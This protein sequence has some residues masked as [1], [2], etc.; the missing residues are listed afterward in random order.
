MN[1][2]VFFTTMPSPIGLLTLTSDGRA[3]TSV[4]FEDDEA[5]QRPP[6]GWLRDER[7]L[8][9]ARRQLEEYFAG[10]RAA[11]DLP[12]A[13]HGTP[14]QLRVWRA[15]CAIPFGTTASYGEIARRIGAPAASRAVGG[16]NHRNPIAIVVPCHRVIG[17]DGSLTGYGGGESRKRKLL[18]LER[19]QAPA[20]AAL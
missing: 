4:R 12:L 1:A 20:L 17:A 10:E 5:A 11:F 15:L 19:T 2:T 13:M 8:R 14:F 3:L 18:D 9:A 6:P 16:A 7:P